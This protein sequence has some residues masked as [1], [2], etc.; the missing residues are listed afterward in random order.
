MR[1]FAG[2]QFEPLSGRDPDSVPTASPRRV[3][4]ELLWRDVFVTARA[5][6]AFLGQVVLQPLLIVFVFG[7]VLTT[8]GYAR[9]GY[10]NILLPGVIAL[11]CVL[12]GLAGTA[13]PMATVA[14]RVGEGGVRGAARA[15]GRADDV[16]DRLGSARAP[17][18]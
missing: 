13:P 2:P 17:A 12:T 8:L 11:T 5:L 3:F 4:L 1:P 14:G 10:D 9:P 6:P 16:P 15:A 7:R 18:V